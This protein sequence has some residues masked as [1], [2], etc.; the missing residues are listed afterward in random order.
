MRQ[1]NAKTQ[2]A[3]EIKRAY[4]DQQAQRLPIQSPGCEY[5]RGDWIHLYASAAL[6]R[7]GRISGSGLI[8]WPQRLHEGDQRGHFRGTYILAVRRHVPASL[9][10]L[11]DELITRETRG[12][13]IQGRAAQT[14]LA[15]EA[16]TIAALLALDENRS[17]EFQRRPAFHI[18]GGNRC[19]CPHLHIGTP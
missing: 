2:P 14:A 18:C 7:L 17:L 9:D 1:F 6:G 10:D 3:S 12:Y 16:V 4:G 15:A 8:R 13:S 11:P 5:C 19:A